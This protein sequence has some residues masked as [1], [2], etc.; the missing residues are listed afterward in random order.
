MAEEL[1]QQQQAE[2]VRVERAKL[3]ACMT[4]PL[5]HKLFR[6]ATTISECLHTFCRRC[7]TRKIEY[8]DLDTCPVCNIDLGPLPLHQLRPDHCLQDFRDKI[9]PYKRKRVEAEAEAESQA[10]ET[11]PSLPEVMPPPLV[12]KPP[13]ETVATVHVPARRKERSLSSL[14]INTPKLPDEPIQPAKR[15]KYSTKK[16][17]V[18]RESVTSDDEEPI[19]NAADG[20]R[21]SSPETLIKIAQSRRQ[22]G[23]ASGTSKRLMLDKKVEEGIEES[24]EKSDLLKPLNHLVEELA[25][26]NKVK[27]NKSNPHGEV[28]VPVLVDTTVRA[29]DIELPNKPNLKEQEDNKPQVCWNEVDSAA[30]TSSSVRPTKLPTVRPKKAAT[31]E[32][33]N[34]S[35][36]ATVDANS[37]QEQRLV[38]IWFSLIAANTQGGGAPLPQIS[39]PY[40]RVK[41]GTLPISAIK[42]YLA[43]K[44][45]LASEAEVELS[46]CGRPLLATLQL[47]NLVQW[48]LQTV[49]APER[50][51]TSVGS[52]AKDFVM[53]LYYSRKAT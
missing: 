10:H 20:D 21:L 43:Q 14:V 2:V 50:T 24:E 42:K 23:T 30:S 53:V 33:L 18:V 1:Q 25:A 6:R 28:S 34:V 13:S 8:E 37:R 19:K 26:A 22:N 7:I 44:L 46:I 45:G 29:N 35:A 31:P 9:F 48:W 12:L 15:A 5:C 51:R 38:P 36:Q 32:A 40:L 4:C 11:M 39:S 49:P 52:S 16:V 27:S 41:D 3:A 17:P 47:R